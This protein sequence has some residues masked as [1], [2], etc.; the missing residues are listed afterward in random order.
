[1]KNERNKVLSAY[2]FNFLQ[3]VFGVVVACYLGSSAII[4]VLVFALVQFIFTK[5][6]F[7]NSGAAM[8]QQVFRCFALAECLKIIV[9]ISMTWFCFNFMEIDFLKYILGLISMHF[10]AFII[11]W[12]FSSWL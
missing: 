12:V 4:A 6:A 5:V 8:R 10:A 3:L 7:K 9:L 1:M 11:P 2:R